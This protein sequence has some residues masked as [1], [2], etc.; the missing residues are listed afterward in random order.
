MAGLGRARWSANGKSLF[1]FALGS[2]AGIFRVALDE[3]QPRKIME[4]GDL[5]L[6]GAMGPWV[7]LTPNEEL[8][9]L[10]DI[11]GAKLYALH[12]KGP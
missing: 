3:H 6:G 1:F 10:C 7:S 12:W 11:G 2:D 4:L 9:L 8:L 5:R